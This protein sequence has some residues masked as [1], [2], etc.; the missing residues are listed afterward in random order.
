[1]HRFID[2]TIGDETKIYDNFHTAGM[3]KSEYMKSV[4]GISNGKIIS[5]EELLKTYTKE[6]QK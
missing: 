1:M 5:G 4:E 2:V 3:L 6:V